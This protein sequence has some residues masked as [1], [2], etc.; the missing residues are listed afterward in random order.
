MSGPLAAGLALIALGLYLLCPSL[1]V[2]VALV[3]GV[4]VFVGFD[5][6]T[7]GHPHG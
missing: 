7:E 4:A 3:F 6:S 1:W 5:W 2:I